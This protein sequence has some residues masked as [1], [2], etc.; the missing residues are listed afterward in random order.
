MKASDILIKV[1]D[2]KSSAALIK[3]L[4]YSKSVTPNSQIHFGAFIGE[5]LLGALA[6]GPSIDKRRM[7]QQLGIGFNES[8]EINRIAFSDI[9]PKNSE[10]RAIGVCLR[11]LKKKYPH[12]K[13][14]ISFADACRCGDGTIYRASG[15]V[16]AGYKKNTTMLD[17][18]NGMIVAD[19]TFNNSVT[20]SYRGIKKSDCK[21]IDGYQMKYIF[22][23]DQEMKAKFKSI[24][25]SEI[26]DHVRMYKGEKR[27]VS[28]D[29]VVHP[30]QG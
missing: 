14:I 19:K 21:P 12:L 8:L 11:L 15:F 23:F 28:K 10:S 3:R 25:F 7:A 22:F 1:I 9:L 30:D 13:C 6:F 26:P 24:P 16:L 4:H 17:A 27:A 29:I 2:S 18:G 20:R 5:T